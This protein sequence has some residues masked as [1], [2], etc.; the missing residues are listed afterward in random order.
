MGFLNGLEKI[1]GTIFKG[2]K[3]VAGIAAVTALADI[4]VKVFT[5]EQQD[6]IMMLQEDVTNL[7]I[8]LN[9]TIDAINSD[10]EELSKLRGDI[11]YLEDKTTAIQVDVDNAKANK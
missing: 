3:I 2:A 6:R 7:R 9:N 4:A 10:K 5:K 1:G 8:G 11:S